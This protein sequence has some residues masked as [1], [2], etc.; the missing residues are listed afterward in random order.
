MGDE[1]MDPRH[2]PRGL[3]GSWTVSGSPR[4]HAPVVDRAQGL[5]RNLHAARNLRKRRRSRTELAEPCGIARLTGLHALVRGEGGIG[6]GIPPG[7]AG[8]TGCVTFA[9]AVLSRRQT[10]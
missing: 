7:H 6:P 5:G 8:A 10:P 3:G 9:F 1:G 2:P 4:R